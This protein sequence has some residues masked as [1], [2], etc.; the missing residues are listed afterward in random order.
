MK[1]FKREIF[2]DYVLEN[3]PI[4]DLMVLSRRSYS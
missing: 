2:Y 3:P 4:Y 1:G